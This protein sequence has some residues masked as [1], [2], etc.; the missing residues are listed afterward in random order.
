M[1]YHSTKTLAISS[2]I[3]RKN[4]LSMMYQK[5]SIKYFAEFSELSDLT[6]HGLSSDTPSPSDDSGY[7]ERR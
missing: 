5:T 3:Y 1:I 2:Y 6:P 7:E 4:T